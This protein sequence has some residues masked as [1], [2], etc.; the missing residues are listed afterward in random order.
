[1]S[2]C[3]CGLFPEHENPRDFQT[4]LRQTVNDTH[5]TQMAEQRKHYADLVHS[6]KWKH[7]GDRD[8]IVVD[9]LAALEREIRGY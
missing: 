8:R 1:M 5:A 2:G 7:M 9:E 4:A 3:A 6:L